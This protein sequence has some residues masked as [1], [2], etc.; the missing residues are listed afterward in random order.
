MKH[1]AH[2]PQLVKTT[3]MM[4]HSNGDHMSGAQKQGSHSPSVINITAIHTER[5]INQLNQLMMIL[6]LVDSQLWISDST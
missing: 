3:G 2:T 6:H 5:H 1:H 4:H